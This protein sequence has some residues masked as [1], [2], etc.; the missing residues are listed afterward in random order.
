MFLKGILP[1][2]IKS[3][4]ALSYA[5]C[6]LFYGQLF[7]KRKSECRG[8]PCRG[9]HKGGV[10]HSSLTV[11]RV[12]DSSYYRK[13]YTVNAGD[14]GNSS[15]LHLAGGGCE[16]I[17]YSFFILSRRDKLIARGDSTDCSGKTKLRGRLR[18]GLNL[19]MPETRPT[20]SPIAEVSISC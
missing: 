7:Y 18:K 12:G 15:A 2:V 19:L 16:G 3:F 8:I 1:Q 11:S 20:G 5:F 17:H 9:G 13:R 6:L 4:Q 10:I 14:M